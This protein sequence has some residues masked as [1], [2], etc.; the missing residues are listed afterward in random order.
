M[1]VMVRMLLWLIPVA[2]ALGTAAHCR[3]R[4]CL[5]SR[6]DLRIWHHHCRSCRGLNLALADP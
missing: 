5:S 3:G 2:N 1:G 4:H 6:S